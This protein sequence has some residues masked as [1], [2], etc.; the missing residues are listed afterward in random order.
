LLNQA[1]TRSSVE[2]L[3]SSGLFPVIHLATHGNFSSDPEQTYLLLSDELL[4]VRS[5]DAVFRLNPLARANVIE[6]LVMSACKTATGDE[7]ATL[8]LAGMAVRSGARSTVATLWPA[9]DDSTAD[10]MPDFYQQLKAGKN[11]AEALRSAQLNLLKR[12]REEQ[13]AENTERGFR[14]WAPYILVGNWL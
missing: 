2:N 12:L 14:K 13:R 9:E 5:M 4:R 11:K 8:G 1:F 10:I 3:V 6:L 7:R